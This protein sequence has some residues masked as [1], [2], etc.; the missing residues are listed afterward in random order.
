MS[1]FTRWR[2]FA[3]RKYTVSVSKTEFRK[4]VF[5]GRDIVSKAPGAPAF[6]AISQSQAL[7]ALG[8]RLR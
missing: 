1:T 7:A 5:V 4:A 2:Q 3:V 6:E 8:D